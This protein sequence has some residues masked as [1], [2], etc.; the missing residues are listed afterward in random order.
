[1]NELGFL[2]ELG[3]SEDALDEDARQVEGDALVVILNQHVVERNR[4]QLEH[5]H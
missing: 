3:S 4:E 1:V 5:D 2:D